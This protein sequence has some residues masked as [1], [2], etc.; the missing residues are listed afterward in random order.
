MKSSPPAPTSA[1]RAVLPPLPPPT[2]QTFSAPTPSHSHTHRVLGPILM[3]IGGR[4]RFRRGRKELLAGSE[5][6]DA[7]VRVRPEEKDV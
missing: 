2:M 6:F 4:N 3:E 1:R 7:P 5:V